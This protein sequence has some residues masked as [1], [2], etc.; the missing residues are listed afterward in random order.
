MTFNDPKNP[1]DCAVCEIGTIGKRKKEG[2]NRS[3][4]FSAPLDRKKTWKEVFFVGRVHPRRFL[5]KSLR[6]ICFVATL[7]PYGKERKTTLF[8]YHGNVRKGQG[9][10]LFYNILF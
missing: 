9:I 1:F 7:P 10:L 2:Q 8:H 6:I 4:N 5:S 3:A